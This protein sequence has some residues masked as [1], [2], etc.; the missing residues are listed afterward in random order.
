MAVSGFLIVFALTILTTG[1][2]EAHH[3]LKGSAASGISIPNLTHGQLGVMTRYR[4]AILA[5]ADSRV[6]PDSVTRT[7]QNFVHLQFAYCL[8][9]LVPGSL[10]YEDS[11]FNGCSHAYL[12][13]TKALLDQLRQAEDTRAKADDLAEEIN[14]AMVQ[15][16]AALEI[17]S[18][19]F[20]PFNTAEIV[21]PEWSNISFN[22]LGLL[23]G[24]IIL[25][26]TALAFAMSRI[27]RTA[28]I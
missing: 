6:S 16:G 3:R 14:R 22:P 9:G 7:L 13:G 11:P 17:C 20:A 8:W 25:G 15:T 21:M 2:A 10:S 24:F 19:S 23:L 26:A 28:S 5:L 1:Y 18:N 12:A 4:S 27:R